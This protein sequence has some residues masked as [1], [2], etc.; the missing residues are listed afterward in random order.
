ML[1]K[2]EFQNFKSYKDLQPLVLNRLTLFSGLN[3]A[4]KSTIAQLLLLL[5]QSMAFINNT[6]KSFI[7][8]LKLNTELL[9]MGKAE[10]ILNDKNKPL[11]I[12]LYFS[13]NRFISFTFSIMKVL[14][15]IDELDETN[16]LRLTELQYCD[17]EKDKSFKLL[18][19]DD[20]WSVQ[21]HSVMVIG[22]VEVSKQ[23]DAYIDNK[24]PNNLINKYTQDN[25]FYPYSS[26]VLFSQIKDLKFFMFVLRDFSISLESL[27][28]CFDAR[29]QEFYN[30]AELQQQLAEKELRNDMIT[31]E[32]SAQD[33][34]D[35]IFDMRTIFF[36]EHI[37]PF[38]GNPCRIYNNDNNPL[39]ALLKRPS[40]EVA[41]R[42]DFEKN[43][44]EYTSLK[45]A[46]KYWLSDV[47]ELCEDISSKYIIDDLVSEVTLIDKMKNKIHINNVGFGVSQI[48]PLVV[49]CLL[50]NNENIIID[51]P[52]SHLHPGLQSKIGNF[53]LHM[54]MLKK[55][56]IIE[57]HSEHIINILNYYSLKYD[58]V[59][60]VVTSYWI[61]KKDNISKIE[62]INYDEYGF[63]CNPPKGFYDETENTIELM[64]KIREKKLLGK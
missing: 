43:K 55:Q 41:Y 60:D 19:S 28:Y 24:V 42:Y 18:F 15:E 39:V 8:Y 9:E 50:L 29:I 32:T 58:K 45:K 2:I 51:E 59:K 14:N 57:T 26:D 36:L 16:S 7:P 38:R 23:I 17:S 53:L 49:N 47:F 46:V 30:P 4:G 63:I 48:I 13:K 27:R 35:L 62:Q 33:L 37:R 31:I 5:S 6:G 11:Y 12:A 64:N 25:P 3:S 21:A 56:L 52:E 10:E 1:E 61:F 22:N 44:I 20:N 34:S 40:I 54:V